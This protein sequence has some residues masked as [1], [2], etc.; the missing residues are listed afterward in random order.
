MKKVRKAVI[1]AAGLGTRVLPA[2]KAMP[3]E[4]IPIVDKPA[5]QYIVEECT[6]IISREE[7]HNCKWRSHNCR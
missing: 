1:P 3:K 5:I 6:E 2:S 7:T 4:M